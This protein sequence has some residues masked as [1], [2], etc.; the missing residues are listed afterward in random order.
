M[1]RNKN[2]FNI[3]Y[4]H[5]ADVLYVTRGQPEYT[6]YVEYADDLILRFTQ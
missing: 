3:V 1:N 5:D 4:D 2:Q 6:D